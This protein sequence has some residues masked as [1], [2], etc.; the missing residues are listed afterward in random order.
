[1]KTYPEIE[2]LKQ[3]FTDFNILIEKLPEDG[4]VSHIWALLT[5]NNKSWEIYVDDEYQDFDKNNLVAFYL[6]LNALEQYR[7]DPDFLVWAKENYI[8]ASNSKWLSYYKSIDTIINEI[9]GIL[10]EINSQISYYDY[11]MHTDLGLA[12]LRT[13]A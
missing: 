9:E 13:D 10:G 4:T 3:Y 5:I 6:T 1:M 8:D 2:K 12:L 11:S 7:D